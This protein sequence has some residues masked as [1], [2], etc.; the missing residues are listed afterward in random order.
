MKKLLSVL[1][2]SSILIFSIGGVVSADPGETIGPT[3]G[4]DNN[5]E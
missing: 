3:S 5:E 2:I 4:S 1:L